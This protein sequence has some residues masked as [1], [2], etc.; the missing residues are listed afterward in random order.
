MFAF[1]DANAQF[2]RKKQKKLKS[3]FFDEES[4]PKD[5]EVLDPDTLR[6][7]FHAQKVGVSL[8]TSSNLNLYYKI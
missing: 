8:D 7:Q 2:S 6:F 3:A 1:G 4:I 5:K